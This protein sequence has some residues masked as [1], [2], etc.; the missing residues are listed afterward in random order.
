M[1]RI[2]ACA[3][4]IAVCLTAGIVHGQ[5]PDEQRIMVA[6]T[7]YVVSGNTDEML[8]GIRAAARERGGYVKFFSKDRIVIRLPHKETAWLA[9]YLREAG[10]VADE[11]IARTDLSETLVDL[12]TRLAA[13]KKLLAD[14]YKVFDNAA[15]LQTLE[16]EKAVGGVIVEI[17][18]LKGKI[19]YYRDR[20]DLPEITVHLTAGPRGAVT[21]SPGSGWEWIRTLGIESIMMRY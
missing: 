19:A 13:K 15:L 20:I 6:Y 14:L 9:R 11:Q 5:K 12:R 17:E 21:G 10:Q 16:V 2:A 8:S 18:E 1:M 4:A 7:Y 3:I